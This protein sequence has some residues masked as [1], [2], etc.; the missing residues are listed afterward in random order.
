MTDFQIKGLPYNLKAYAG[1]SLVGQY[2]KHFAQIDQVMDPRFPITGQGG[3]A[4][5]ILIRA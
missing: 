4:N 1:L 3:I 2:L 5:S